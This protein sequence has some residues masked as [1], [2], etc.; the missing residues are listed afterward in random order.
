MQNNDVISFLIQQ[1]SNFARLQVFL[2]LLQ[3][4]LIAHAEG[5]IALCCHSSFGLLGA[6]FS[7]PL[8]K[9]VDFVA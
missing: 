3:V 2:I 6:M 9:G 1:D 4:G 5:D 7:T 8:R